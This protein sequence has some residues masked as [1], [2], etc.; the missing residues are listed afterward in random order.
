MKLISLNIEGSK[1]LDR[2]IP[3]IE[4]EQPDVLCLQELPYADIP[5]FAQH[6]YTGTYLPMARE[7][8]N[9]PHACM[10]I[11]L[12]S[13]TPLQNVR[14]FYYP[15]SYPEIPV[16]NR[17]DIANS[18]AHGVIF[19]EIVYGTS[20][21][22]IGTTHFTWTPYGKNPC[23]TQI[24]H[25]ESFL[26]CV[27]REESHLI[28]GDFNVPRNINPLYQK[29]LTQY[30]DTVP[31]VYSSS[32]DKSLHRHGTNPEKSIMFESFMVD[33]VF[34]QLPYIASNVRLE[35]GLSDH[36]AVVATISKTNS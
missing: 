22:T 29:L 23:T 21:F 36:A 6:G 26:A 4:R 17:A 14:T 24:S 5:L 1:H 31:T 18:V 3:F 10:G 25:M 19:A 12:F 33:Y 35:F 32:L 16:F 15:K 13:K 20:T 28:C 8:I 2:V 9:N 7:N 11:A 30:T 34:T 27:A